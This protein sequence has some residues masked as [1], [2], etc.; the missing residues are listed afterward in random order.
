MQTPTL[1][2]ISDAEWEIMRVVWTNQPVTSR[3]ITDVLEEKMDWKSA[4]VKT[5][6]GRLV[7]K[8]FISIEPDGKRYL[9]SATISEEE[10]V[11]DMT[12]HVLSYVCSTKIG[13]TIA[14][15]IEEVLLSKE[16]V[17]LLEEVIRNKRKDA[18][19]A[20]VCTCVP[21]QCDC[22]HE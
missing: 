15:L 1:P 16:D 20:I 8:G 7:E 6:I 14:S 2:K 10:S 11:R 12:D 18:V 22:H 17:E 4:T 9:Y 19:D 3:F 5:L 21:G 13:S